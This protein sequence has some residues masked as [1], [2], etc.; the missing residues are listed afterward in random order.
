MISGQSNGLFKKGTV[1][2]FTIIKDGKRDRKIFK[3]ED[4]KVFYEKYLKTQ[5]SETFLIRS[6]GWEALIIFSNQ[7]Q[8]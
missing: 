4:L 1:Q 6:P 3:H 8:I 2:Y 7:E 5:E